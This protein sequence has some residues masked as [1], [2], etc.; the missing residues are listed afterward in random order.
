MVC[1][2][3]LGQPH[4][5]YV[6]RNVHSGRGPHEPAICCWRMRV[7]TSGFV[8][9]APATLTDSSESA[10][11]LALTLEPMDT[12]GINAFGAEDWL[13][14]DY[15]PNGVAEPLPWSIASRRHSKGCPMS[16]RRCCSARD[17]GEGECVLSVGELSQ[18]GFECSGTESSGGPFCADLSRSRRWKAA[19][20]GLDRTREMKSVLWPRTGQGMVWIDA[21]DFA[22]AYTCMP[23]KRRGRISQTRKFSVAR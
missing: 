6:E 20:F 21:M 17:R 14:A 16:A 3:C 13:I 12:T 19:D 7:L 5:G 18:S 15:Y 2:Q 4:D 9:R 8:G 22:P 11:P 10:V 1:D 23:S